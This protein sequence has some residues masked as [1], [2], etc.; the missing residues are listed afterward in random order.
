ML[1]LF[2]LLQL[3]HWGNYINEMFNSWLRPSDCNSD[4]TGYLVERS[5]VGCGG[6]VATLWS[7]QGK[8]R[9]LATRRREI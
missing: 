6:L 8:Y 1:N 9:P 7:Y 4:H 5:L 3:L 2:N